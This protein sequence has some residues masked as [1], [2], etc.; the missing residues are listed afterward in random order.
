MVKLKSITGHREKGTLQIFNFFIDMSDFM[1][2]SINLI[3]QINKLN[4]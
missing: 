4:T 3:F 2:K 1:K